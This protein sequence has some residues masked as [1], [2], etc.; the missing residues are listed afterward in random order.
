[1]K[2]KKLT[3]QAFGPYP[4]KVV[5]DF[6]NNDINE[7]LLLL[8]GDTGAGKTTIFDAIAYVLFDNSSGNER[9]NYSLRSDYA[10]V[11]DITYV[12]LEFYYKGQLHTIKRG[13]AYERKKKRGEGTTK[14]PAF[15]E[16]ELNGITYSN[17]SETNKAIIDLLGIDYKQFRQIVMLAQGDFTNLLDSNVN[18]TTILF[19]KIFNTQ[20][21][22]KLMDKL[23]EETNSLNNQLKNINEIINNERERLD[24]KY[25]SFDNN[26]LLIELKKDILQEDIQENNLKKNRDDLNKQLIDKEKQLQKQIDINKKIDKLN[27]YHNQL[28][29]LIKNNTDINKDKTRRDYNRDIA[30]D[31]SNCL[32]NI[33]NLKTKI[34]RSNKD[35]IDLNNKQEE[36]LNKYK[37]NEDKFKQLDL[38]PDQQQALSEE[39]NN[40]NNYLKELK[41]AKKKKEDVVRNN[42][43][44]NKLNETI[45]DLEKQIKQL[46]DEYYFDIYS[47]A[48]DKLKDNEPCPVCGS[49]NH[50]KKAIKHH[51][52]VKLE[53]INKL[54]DR[55]K[56]LI[57]ERQQYKTSRENTIKELETKNLVNID[58]DLSIDN[59]NKDIKSLDEQLLTLN[60]SYNQIKKTKDDLD[61]LITSIKTSLDNTNKNIKIY[62]LDL[63]KEETKLNNIYTS[64]NTNHEEYLKMLLNNDEYLKLDKKVNDYEYKYNE[65]NITINNLQGD[66]KGLTKIDTNSLEEELDTLKSAYIDLDNEYSEYKTKLD[67]KKDITNR[68]DEEYT[69]SKDLNERYTLISRLSGLANGDIGDKQKMT[70]EN[71]IQS[72]YIDEVL[73]SANNR[74]YKMSDKRYRLV[75]KVEP[76]KEDKKL[77]IVFMAYDYDTYTERNTKNLSGGEKFIVALSLALGISDV[78]SMN[79]GGIKMNS[80]FID[81]GFG[82]LDKE[83]LDK[84]INALEDLSGQDKLVGIISHVEDLVDQI[85]KK[86]IVKKA[87][88]GSSIEV[89]S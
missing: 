77:G 67:N 15:V 70:F 22:G 86:I 20:V 60:N 12:E 35:L 69:K 46:E 57:I 44:E 21:Y 75:K 7:G 18:S 26:N 52:G 4:G 51:T 38:Y 63:N 28:D 48:A 81:E 17:N 64:K 3:M 8:T 53:D 84:A 36:T 50:P 89:V 79:A 74:L 23:K 71:Y 10:D 40:K 56:D 11:D 55:N 33:N 27:D 65:L 85:D 29:L 25:Y 6:E 82:N 78:I 58:I 83:S 47:V 59:T 41:E 42:D 9:E 39:K 54:R 88:N 34:E 5:I 37:Q 80:L 16:F 73:N 87:K 30:K 32:N 19:R 43:K 1:M 24:N 49:L 66:V 45:N 76:D 68:I 13:P 72:H 14:E 2:L 61:N 62:E 31:I